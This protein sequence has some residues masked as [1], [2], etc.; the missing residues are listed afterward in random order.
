MPPPS[1][2]TKARGRHQKSLHHFKT[3]EGEID[4][5]ERL[6]LL[7]RRTAHTLLLGTFLECCVAGRGET[8][9]GTKEWLKQW[10]YIPRSFS[11]MV[12]R[13]KI[14]VSHAWPS[15]VQDKKETCWSSSHIHNLYC[16]GGELANTSLHVLLTR[17]HW[18]TSSS[19]KWE[20]NFSSNSVM[21]QTSETADIAHV[22]RDKL[23]PC[24]R[25]F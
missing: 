12:K 18:M 15:V 24:V 17:Q 19:E 6:G 11:T 3:Q 20:G 14:Y 1:G 2:V 7:S 22:V 21:C 10:D 13:A 8:Y 16:R 23:P 4:T 5:C 9:L 25:D